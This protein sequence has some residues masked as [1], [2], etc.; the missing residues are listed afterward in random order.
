[1]KP[2]LF[3]AI[4]VLIVMAG[5]QGLTKVLDYYGFG[6]NTPTKQDRIEENL[7]RLGEE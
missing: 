3:I 6:P 4:G 1:M 5:V 7:R 2:I